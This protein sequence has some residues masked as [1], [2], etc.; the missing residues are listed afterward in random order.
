MRS[1]AE[2]S[3]GRMDRGRGAAGVTHPTP[4][5]RRLTPPSGQLSPA[6]PRRRL[7]LVDHPL[8]VDAAAGPRPYAA[9]RPD[10]IAPIASRA[11]PTAHRSPHPDRKPGV[12][13]SR[14]RATESGHEDGTGLS[15]QAAAPKAAGFATLPWQAEG[16]TVCEP[17]RG[18][19]VKAH[20]DL[21]LLFW[22]PS[23]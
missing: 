5:Q 17:R 19:G 14:A 21:D 2:T 4:G 15:Y 8:A 12:R 6:R 9:A 1:L 3:G 20:G 22:I 18:S 16:V 7:A 11:T 13:S 10:E 23:T